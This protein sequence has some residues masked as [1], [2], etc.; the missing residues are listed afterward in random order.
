MTISI[1][2][3]IIDRRDPIHDNKRYNKFVILLS[4]DDA[5]RCEISKER[6]A[7]IIADM[8]LSVL[9]WEKEHGTPAKNVTK[10]KPKSGRESKILLLSHDL[11]KGE[12]RYLGKRKQTKS[13]KLID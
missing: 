13:K 11:P 9:A 4:T 3:C 7:E 6:L 2:I 12:V 5:R 10:P 8:L 1:V